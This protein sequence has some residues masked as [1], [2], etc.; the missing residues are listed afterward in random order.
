MERRRLLFK[1]TRLEARLILRLQVRI[2]PVQIFFTE[3][4]QDRSRGLDFDPTKRRL[5][6]A[7]F[8]QSTAGCYS[9]GPAIRW[10]DPEVLSSNLPSAAFLS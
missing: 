5:Y 10:A 9:M 7:K 6:F 2:C 4:S 8:L 3:F 1:G